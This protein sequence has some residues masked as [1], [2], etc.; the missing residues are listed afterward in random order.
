MSLRSIN[1]VKMSMQKNFERFFTKNAPGQ[2][3]E[4]SSP[5]IKNTFY[6]VPITLH[7]VNIA[8]A[9]CRQIFIFFCKRFAGAGRGKANDSNVFNTGKRPPKGPSVLSFKKPAKNSGWWPIVIGFFIGIIMKMLGLSIFLFL[10]LL[11]QRLYH[12][13][14]F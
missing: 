6:G 9:L 4:K 2:L 14:A 8:K 3:V 12:L 13:P 10:L 1:F 11:H 7:Y 5:V